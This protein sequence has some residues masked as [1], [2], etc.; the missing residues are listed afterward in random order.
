MTINVKGFG[1]I[2]ADENKIDDLIYYLALAGDSMIA[3]SSDSTK[4]QSIRRGAQLIRR[5]IFGL[6][7]AITEGVREVQL[8]TL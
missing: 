7:D 2:V 1:G 3:M 8:E 6:I 4:S 5:D